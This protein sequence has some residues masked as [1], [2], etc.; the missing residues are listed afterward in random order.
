MGHF[1]VVEVAASGEP[2]PTDAALVR[3]L[4]TVDAPVGVQA[5]AGGET[6]GADITDM[7]SLP[8]VDADVTL[9]QRG[10]VEGLAAVVARQHVLLPPP[11]HRYPG[12]RGARPCQ[13]TS[14]R[15]SF[16]GGQ[17]LD[18]VGKA[19]RVLHRHVGCVRLGGQHLYGEGAGGLW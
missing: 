13:G 10:A 16:G 18:G 4:T 17:T 15:L 8:G 7:G 5:G 11:D 6:L 1:V 2:L 14:G 9:E 19:P 3:L 12:R